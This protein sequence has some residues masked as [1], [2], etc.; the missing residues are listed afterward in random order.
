M[1]NFSV[2]SD[3][4][5]A[6]WYLKSCGFEYEIFPKENVQKALQTIFAN[7]VKKF[8][9]GQKGAVNGFIPSDGE[10][11]GYV[12]RTSMQSEEVWVGV[13]YALASTMIQEGMIDEGFETAA[14]L[15]ETLTQKIGLG[16][17][18]PEAIYEKNVYRSLGYMR[19]LSIYSMLT[20]IEKRK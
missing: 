12:D 9:D 18:T 11:E 10:K 5:C 1:C 2:T 19:P 6:Q 20:A 7:N 15:Y 14:G 13:T 17:E 8:C 16:F 4:L 3:Q